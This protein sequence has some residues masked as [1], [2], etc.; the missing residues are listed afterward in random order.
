MAL[1]AAKLGARRVYA[2]EPSAALQLG[3]EAARANGLAERIEFFEMLAS[4]V[5]LPEPADVLVSDLR[6]TLPLYQRHLPSIADVRRRLLAPGATIIPREDSLWAAIVE[7]H[8]VHE[9]LLRPWINNGYGVDLSAGRGMATSSLRGVRLKAEQL[10]SPSIAWETLDY[11]IR[12]R[13]NADADVRFEIDRSGDGHGIGLWFDSVLT[14]GV[15]I[16]N[17]PGCAQLIY[18]QTLLPWPEAVSLKRSDEITVSLRARLAGHDYA[19]RWGTRVERRGSL[20]ATFEQSSLAG[21]P[22]S[23]NSLHKRREAHVPILNED[24]EVDRDVLNQID[25]QR[26]LG[27]VARLLAERHPRRFPTWKEALRRACAL[28]SRYR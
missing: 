27:E 25:G 12:E 2:V 11:R 5:T 1:I 8:E 16:T 9:S 21:A 13:T 4:E 19:W 22:L 17:A 14:E 23:L 24:G 15:S 26:T 6:S 28:S 18:G 10:L 7:A 3:R 20:V